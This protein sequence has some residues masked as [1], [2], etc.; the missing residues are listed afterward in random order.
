[1]QPGI[2]K[3]VR[4]KNLRCH[5]GLEVE[6]SD[7]VT[8]IC[9]L[10]GSGK[11]SVLTAIMLALGHE[12]KKGSNSKDT[13]A[14]R[15]ES[16]IKHGCDNAIVEVDLRNEGEETVDQAKYGRT[17]GCVHASRQAPLAWRASD[18]RTDRLFEL[19][20]IDSFRIGQG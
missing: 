11:S 16:V 4:M 6:L 19:K 15:Y 5:A 3:T 17:I 12:P 1:M 7:R 8:F 18:D 10:N 13:T 9:G 14:T 2:I 20:R